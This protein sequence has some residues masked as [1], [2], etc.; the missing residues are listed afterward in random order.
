VD[1]DVSEEVD[2]FN[3]RADFILEDASGMFLRN[4]GTYLS[5]YTT[6]L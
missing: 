1:I 6:V 5:D 2:A 4:V 3:M